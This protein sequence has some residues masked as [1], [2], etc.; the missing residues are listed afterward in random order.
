MLIVNRF[1]LVV[2]FWFGVASPTQAEPL[3]VV[4]GQS[5]KFVKIDKSLEALLDD[6]YEITSM[7]SGIAGFVYTLRKDHK[8]ALCLFSMSGSDVDT[9]AVSKCRSLN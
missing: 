9:T 5:S 3:K 8:W 1:I 4:G 7:T 6:D 2:G